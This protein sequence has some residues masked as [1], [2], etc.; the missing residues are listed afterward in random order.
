MSNLR[1]TTIQ[2][3]LYWENIEANLAM[4]SEKIKNLKGETDI[5]IL[6]EMFT[7][8]FSMNPI[9]LGERMNGKTM[10]WLS[11]KAEEINAVVTGSLIIKEGELFYNRFLLVAPNGKHL[12]W[13][14]MPVMRPE[15]CH[16]RVQKGNTI[17]RAEMA[18][19]PGGHFVD[20]WRLLADGKGSDA[21][22]IRLEPDSKKVRVRA[23]DGIHLSVAGAHHVTN[24]VRDVIH[25]TLAGS[26]ADPPQPPNPPAQPA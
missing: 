3:N 6:P 4:F 23:G 8:G 26:P 9:H 19:R 5:I 24:T 18:M 14:V 7:T 1:I 22:R 17:F 21:D 16:L 2:S 12:F 25:T 10:E 15:K 11:Q 20:I 13:I